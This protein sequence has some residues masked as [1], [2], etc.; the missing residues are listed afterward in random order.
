MFPV[1]FAKVVA[2]IDIKVSECAIQTDSAFVVVVSM[3]NGTCA[4]IPPHVIIH[5]SEAPYS[6]DIQVAETESAKGK[7]E[8]AAFG[9]GHRTLVTQGHR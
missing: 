1:A 3:Q 6:V 5:Q 8:T 4:R 7:P 2:R 9:I